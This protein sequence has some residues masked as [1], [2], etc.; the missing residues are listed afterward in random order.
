M[1]PKYV[2]KARQYIFLYLLSFIKLFYIFSKDMPLKCC[3]TGFKLV[4][5][6]SLKLLRLLAFVFPQ[7]LY[8]LTVASPG[9]QQTPQ[10]YIHTS[11]SC[12]FQAAF[13]QLAAFCQFPALF[14]IPCLEEKLCNACK[15]IHN[16]HFLSNACKPFKLCFLE[17][18][19][20]APAGF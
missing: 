12:F 18:C 2:S 8:T 14:L 13:C 15:P 3:I 10:L 17:L 19:K 20:P 16:L 6:F 1:Y 9:C 5:F 4:L 11:V 7:A